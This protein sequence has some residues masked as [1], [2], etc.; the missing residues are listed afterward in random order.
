MPIFSDDIIEE[1]RQRNDI[2]DVVS[3]YVHLTKKGSTYFGLCPFHNEKTGSF[4]VSPH[5][6]MYYCFGCG[7]GGNVFTFLMQYENFTFGEAMEVLADRAGVAL[8][9]YEMSE[10]QKREADKKQRLLDINKEAAKYFYTLLRNE[11]GKHAHAYFTKRELTEETMRKFGLGYSDQY[12]NDLYQYLRKK[13]YDDAIL[14]ESGLVTIDERRG[15]YDKFWNRAMF[16]IMDVR[17]KVIGFGGRVMG[18]GEPKYLNS[19]ETPIFDK[20]R[21]LYGLNF[22]RSTK[23]PQLLLCEGY[24][25]VIAL[26]QAGFDNAVASLGTALTS[27]H[28]NL[29]KRYTKEVYITYDSDGAGTKAALR[30][31][32]ILK[33][34]G[35]TTKIVNMKPYKDPDEFIKALGAEEY[36]KRIDE[37]ENS[38][39]FEIRIMQNEYDLTDPEGKSKFY[40]EI[41]KKL[42]SFTE[43]IERDIYV[44]AVAAKYQIPIAD[45]QK[46]VGRYGMQ[47]TGETQERTRLKSG[48]NENNTQ[49][50]GLKKNEGM[51][52]SQ[53]LLLTWLIENTGL[54]QK[55]KKYIAPEDFT[56]E[57]Y[58]KVAELLFAQFEEHGQANP[59]QIINCFLEEEE[60]KEVAG[61]FNARIHE[62]ETKSEMEKALKETLLRVKENSLKYR[63]EHL[64]PTDMEGLLR[65]VN[66]KKSLE[67]LKNLHI[68]IG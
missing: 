67:E 59:A 27:G 20:S 31:I 61:L 9:K 43:K 48:I 25:D 66:D 37:A 35:L 50:N 62:V 65:V 17:N 53:K 13:G 7:A 52:Q 28:A 21:N 26:H 8:P 44:E 30:A 49:R 18:E 63:S 46:L 60:Q 29:L 64:A 6:Q 4:S 3:Q 14:K 56:E 38:F 36:Q 32:P 2:V 11:R 40:N 54:Y 5:K 39:L 58:F 41:A 12:S 24:M 19:P 22:A 42:C 57:L 23:K 15:G 45:L 33:E 16:P 47:M 1:V 51:K 10:A 68:S 34:V 55:I